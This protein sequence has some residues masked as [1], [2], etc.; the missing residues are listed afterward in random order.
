MAQPG[1]KLVLHV[2][3]ASL[4]RDNETFGTMDPYCQVIY[5]GTKHRS[6]THSDGGKHPKWNYRLELEVLDVM[7]EITFKVYNSNT[8]ED[9]QIAH[10]DALKIYNLIGPNNGMTEN[11]H[12]IYEKK[13]RGTIRVRTQ[14]IPNAP[15]EVPEDPA[16]AQMLEMQ[17][18]Q[19]EMQRLQL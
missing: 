8:F 6:E 7:D 19:M 1:G 12:M 10:T 13:N 2:E 15:A 16:A 9:D 3:E 14:Y 11:H 4:T 17:K 5:N 18:Q